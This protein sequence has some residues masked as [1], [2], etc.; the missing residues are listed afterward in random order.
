MYSS[1]AVAQRLA[2]GARQL[3]DAETDEHLGGLDAHDARLIDEPRQDRRERALAIADRSERRRPP[4]RE[5]T[6]SGSA[7]API[8]AFTIAGVTSAASA[9][10]DGRST[11]VR[12]Y[13]RERVVEPSS[14]DVC[15]WRAGA[16]RAAGRAT[17]IRVAPM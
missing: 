17:P 13:V 9:T 11:I 8:S 16:R 1:C 2:G 6:G 7:A 14:N 4:T 5:P 10:F 12:R 15:V 3:D